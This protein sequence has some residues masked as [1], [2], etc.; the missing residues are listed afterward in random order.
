MAG[1]EFLLGIFTYN[2]G[3]CVYNATM[4]YMDDFW[5]IISV[6]P[7]KMNERIPFQEEFP[8]RDPLFRF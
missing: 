1:Y 4:Q 5:V 3:W 6:P 7:R 2:I 8:L